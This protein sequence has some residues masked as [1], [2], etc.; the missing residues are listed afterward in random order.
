MCGIAGVVSDAPAEVKRRWVEQMCARLVHRGP[1]DSGYYVDEWVALGHRRLSVIDVEGGAQ[2]MANEDGRVQVV[3]NGEIYNFLELREDLIRRGHQFRTRCDT[4]V[5]V[6]LW[7]ETGPSLVEHLNGMFAFGLWDARQRVVLLARD[8]A[9][10]KP[11]YYSERVPESRLCFASE[12]KALMALPGFPKDIDWQAV[13]DFLSLSYIPDPETIYRGVRRL[14]PG[15][16][17][18]LRP[19]GARRCKYWQPR[20]EPLVSWPQP[21][22]AEK[23]REL[24]DDAVRRR[25]ISDVPLGA[26][27]SGGVDSSAVVATMK[28]YTGQVETF[29]IGFREE[30]YNEVRYARAVARHCQ[31]RHREEVVRPSIEDILP[32]LVEAYD[33]PFGDSSAIPTMYLARMTRQYV[34]VALSGDGADEVFGGY[35]RYRWAVWEERAREVFPAGWRRAVFGTLARYYPKLDSMPQWLRAKTLL[36]N[37]ATDL[38]NAYFRS[39]AT[40]VDD[41]LD[42]IAG[43]ELRQELRFVT[44]RERFCA[45]FRKYGHL[46]PL[47]QVQAVDFET[48]LPGDILVKVDR[49]TMAFSLECRCPWLDYR[50]IEFGL[51][52]PDESK[53]RGRQGKYIFKV[54]MESR[55][56]RPVVWRKKMG[57]SVP[58]AEWFRGSLGRLFEVLVS[59]KSLGRFVDVAEAHRLYQEHR[60]G[61]W[62]H[63]RKLWNLVVLACWE[64]W[65]HRS[66]PDL[67]L[68]AL[69]EAG[70]AV[71]R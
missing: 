40:F 58:L 37:L 43:P 18:L 7:E 61:R 55:L 44:P 26:F 56:P 17:L 39:V 30:L 50:F 25:L 57:F 1:D 45:R 66:E 6:H 49:A 35:R 53:I 27:L 9:G 51:R 42:R 24:A 33:E 20:F 32:R 52:L 68:G 38:P 3:F 46:T 12:L 54:A 70:R 63:D 29:S 21:R 5:L 34:T 4:E 67:V 15:E 19:E 8:R 69:E 2:P 47:Q 65:H 10:K 62:N 23:L 31:T 71:A 14:E 16:W 48:Y 22:V 60:S 13:A 28:A 64:T 41:Q 11:L 36:S 59:E